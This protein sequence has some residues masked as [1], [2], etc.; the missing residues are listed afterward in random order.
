MNRRTLL[1]TI[2]GLSTGLAGCIGQIIS[3]AEEYDIGMSSNAF[4]PQT[5]TISVGDTVIWRNTSSRAH[6]VTAYANAI[7]G[8]AEYFASGGFE[9]EQVARHAWPTEGSL[10]GS[11]E[12]EHAFDHRGEYRYF[13]IPHEIV[14]QGKILVTQ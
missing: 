14:M 3:P 13:C 9:S 6:T 7:P 10:A 1:A 5:Y 12:F 8:P 2:G 11:Q 4:K